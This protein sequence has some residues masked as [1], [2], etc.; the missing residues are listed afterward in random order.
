M[1][2]RHGS[3]HSLS[4]K[5]LPTK[6]ELTANN[7]DGPTSSFKRRS[8][9]GDFTRGLNIKTT[10]ESESMCKKQ[11]MSNTCTGTALQGINPAPESNS[12]S[13]SVRNRRAINDL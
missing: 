1:P 3:V 10:N 9:A 8:S 12:N 13:N 5:K 4:K 2:R 6:M 11:L 7:G